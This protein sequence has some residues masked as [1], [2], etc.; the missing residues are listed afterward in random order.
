MKDRERS[1]FELK[2]QAKNRRSYEADVSL[3]PNG[4]AEATNGMS[5]TQ[6]LLHLSNKD[7]SP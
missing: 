1:L 6:T 7:V 5:G 4:R 3:S 2:D